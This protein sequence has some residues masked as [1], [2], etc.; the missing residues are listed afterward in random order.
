MCES[1]AAEKLTDLVDVRVEIVEA[2]KPD[3][4]SGK[5]SRVVNL[6]GPPPGSRSQ[7]SVL[8]TLTPDP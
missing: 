2:I 5:R 3:P 1:V 7:G 4:G 6:V 8:S